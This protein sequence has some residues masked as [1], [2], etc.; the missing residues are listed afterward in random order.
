M[1]LNEPMPLAIFATRNCCQPLLAAA[2][3]QAVEATSRAA[4]PCDRSR[5]V[6]HSSAMMAFS[7]SKALSL[8][9]GLPVLLSSPW[10]VWGLDPTPAN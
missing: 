8:L 4:L 7:L 10:R 6:N 1:V 3:Y 2:L 9:A 5:P